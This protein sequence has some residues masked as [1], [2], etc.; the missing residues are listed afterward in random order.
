M[1][2]T[3]PSQGPNVS[4]STYSYQYIYDYGNMSNVSIEDDSE[5]D[6]GLSFAYK[7]G[8]FL[9]HYYT[10]AL[11]FVGSIGNILS[12]IVFFKTKLRKLSSSYYLAALGISDTCF[13]IGAFV[14][15]LNYI[16][17]NIYNQNYY[18]QFFTYISGL[19]SFLSVWFVV[20]F[21]VERFIAVLYPLKRQTMC[22]VKRACSV[23]IG[24]FL[25]GCVISV[26]YF[27][28]AAPQYSDYL[29][30]YVCDVREEYK[31]S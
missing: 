22:T 2:E 30:D 29:K 31:V 13:L 9:T 4:D 25:L 11:V 8:D 6:F 23:L 16:N 14:S 27:V 26:P 18:C 20:A 10:P 1:N 15:W 19:C 17:I 5:E 7:V 28:Y 3:V 12:V 21:T 24:L